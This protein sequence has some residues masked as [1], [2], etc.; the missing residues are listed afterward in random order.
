MKKSFTEH[1]MII[2]YTHVFANGYEL[3]KVA[4]FNNTVVSEVEVRSWLEQG[5]LDSETK[6]TVVVMTRKQYENLFDCNAST[7][8]DAHFYAD[9]AMEQKEQM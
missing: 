8:E 9:L 1:L 2:E 5:I 3:P 7:S 6:Q 4:M